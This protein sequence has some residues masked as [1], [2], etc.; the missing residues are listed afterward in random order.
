MAR[1]PARQ[2]SHAGTDGEGAKTTQE[3]CCIRMYGTSYGGHVTGQIANAEQISP[4]I[5]YWKDRIR[6]D[7][8]VVFGWYVTSVGHASKYPKHFSKIDYNLYMLAD[9]DILKKRD[10]WWTD[11]TIPGWFD[12]L[13][14]NTRGLKKGSG[15][16]QLYWFPG[17]KDRIIQPYNIH[18]PQ[19]V[20]SEFNGERDPRVHI[21]L[22]TPIPDELMMDKFICEYLFVSST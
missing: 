3:P 21:F 15:N 13:D 19:Y 1:L 9:D 16:T 10:R 17:D 11:L 2:G 18:Q 22:A 12:S 14:Y 6:A 8:G 7:L 20:H 5:V 4:Q